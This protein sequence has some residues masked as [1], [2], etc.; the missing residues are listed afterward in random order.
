MRYNKHVGQALPRANC[1]QRSGFVGQGSPCGPD[2]SGPPAES[3]LFDYG[4]GGS[5]GQLVKLRADW[6]SAQGKLRL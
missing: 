5:V 2:S 1:P 3:R 6:Q 4:S